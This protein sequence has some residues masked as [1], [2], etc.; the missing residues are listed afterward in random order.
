MASIIACDGC[1]KHSPDKNGY[2]I[3]NGWWHVKVK[4]GRRGL[5]DNDDFYYTKMIFCGECYE[6]K[7]KPVSKEMP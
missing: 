7:L 2:H 6:T 4:D 5:G 3:A 1:G